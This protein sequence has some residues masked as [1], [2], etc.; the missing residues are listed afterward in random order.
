MTSLPPLL[1]PLLLLLPPL[2]L[3]LPPL[4]LLLPPLLLRRLRLRPR[5]MR[6][7]IWRWRWTFEHHLI[8]ERLQRM[9]VVLYQP[10]S[11][12]SISGQYDQL[13]R[14]HSIDTK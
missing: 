11:L 9:S 14:F 5:V 4:L 8:R 7:W 12:D 1:P 6:T 2:L 13:A 10:Y 3:R